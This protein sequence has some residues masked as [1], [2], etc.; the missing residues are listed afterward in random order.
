MKKLLCL[1]LVLT[2]LVFTA[3]GCG[4]QQAVKTSGDQPKQVVTLKMADYFPVTH[5]FST[6][7]AKYY[8]QEVEKR[9][10][11]K[12]KIDYYPSEQLGKLKDLL[13]ITSQGITD[14][15]LVCPSFIAGQVPL[16]TV[17]ILPEYTTASEGSAILQR[18]IKGALVDEYK[19]YNVKP[20]FG[21]T[22]PQY[23][24][25]T[26]KKPI[27]KVEDFKGMKLKTSGGLYDKIAEK[28]GATPVVVPSP[29]IYEAT[30]KGVVDG[31]FLNYVSA[32]SYRVNELEKYH[33]YGATFGGYPMIYAINEKSWQ[34]LSPD[35]QKILLEA[36]EA[37]SKRGGEA[38]DKHQDELVKQFESQGMKIY[39]L[40]PED[41][42]QW[43]EPFKDVAQDW[44]KDMEGKGLPG[45]KVYEEFS[46]ACKEIA[47][48]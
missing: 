36:G 1:A 24:V 7:V 2:L 23:D 4:G 18:L 3:A 43:K 21:F 40:T 41:K 44:V 26:V 45:K 19:K 48:Q 13:N 6:E 30:Q 42:K 10:E 20:I 5:T 22:T 32:K 25:G 39:R 28:L 9:S 15:G 37:A 33:T 14:I 46:K 16:N 29:E 17:M 34:K 35:I 38:I 27:T 11:G 8:I 47:K 12:V 31:N